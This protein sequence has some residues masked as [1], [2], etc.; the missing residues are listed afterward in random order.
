MPKTNPYSTLKNKYKHE[1]RSMG[2]ILKFYDGLLDP[3]KLFALLAAVYTLLGKGVPIF[4]DLEAMRHDAN[5]RLYG[6]LLLF[7]LFLGVR[8]LQSIWLARLDY[9]AL[10]PEPRDILSFAAIAVFVSGVI[11]RLMPFGETRWLSVGYLILCLI[12]LI[13]FNGLCRDRISPFSG[14]FDV[15][16]ERRIQ[17]FNLFT[18]A[19]ASASMAVA[20]VVVWWFPQHLRVAE[21]A[22]LTTLPTIAFNALHASQL[23][24]APKF[25]FTNER[26]KPESMIAEAR[27][28]LRVSKPTSDERALG[29][30]LLGPEYDK[31]RLVTLSRATRRHAPEIAELLIREFGYIYNYIFV[32]TEDESCELEIPADKVEAV[33]NVL[34]RM[35]VVYGG[36]GARGFTRYYAIENKEKKTVGFILPDSENKPSVY[37]LVE[38]MVVLPS[39]V[40]NFGLSSIPRILRHLKRVTGAQ[41]KATSSEVCLTHIIIKEQRRSD[42]YGTS[43]VRLLVNALKQEIDDSKVRRIVTLVRQHNLWSRLLFE[44]E[45]FIPTSRE[46]T[47][48]HDDP[49]QSC[50]EI[51]EPIYL[52]YDLK[53][54]D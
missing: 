34:V 48:V 1:N 8:L 26:D 41:P 3:A 10:P 35:L 7:T 45:G 20:C 33:R 12:G 24:H 21:L 31:F 15:V 39:V 40:R 18:F 38:W 29:T 19:H 9:Q 53:T 44:N 2:T 6:C 25:L 47:A 30:A 51:G 52:Q 46:G 4:A 27:A 32:S 23:T 54:N 43:T 36:F 13:H 28:R 17:G 42:R 37:G 22:V 14:A 16:I 49:F 11:P 5:A 50:E